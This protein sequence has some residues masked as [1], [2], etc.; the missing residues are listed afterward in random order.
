MPVDITENFFFTEYSDGVYFNGKATA[1]A[2]NAPTPVPNSYGVTSGY[3]SSPNTIQKFSFASD[4]N[5]TSVG[6]L[7]QAT[8]TR[9]GHQV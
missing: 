9:A 5:A 4:G 6:N 8:T 3:V 7:L 1:D 2:F